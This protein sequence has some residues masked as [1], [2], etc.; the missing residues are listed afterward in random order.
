MRSHHGPVADRRTDRGEARGDA[1]A[2]EE[3]VPWQTVRRQTVPGRIPSRKAG[4]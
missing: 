2:R 3:T 4:A 1:G